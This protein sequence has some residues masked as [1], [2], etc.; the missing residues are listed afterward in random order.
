M[1]N[2]DLLSGHPMSSHE[3]NSHSKLD[4]YCMARTVIRQNYFLLLCV[5]FSSA[6]SSRNEA[7][8]ASVTN[9]R[10]IS[11][12]RGE[13][14]SSVP[15][16]EW[17]PSY[18]SSSILPVF[19]SFTIRLKESVLLIAVMHS[20]KTKPKTQ[21]ERRVSNISVLHGNAHRLLVT[22]TITC[23]DLHGY[24]TSGGANVLRTSE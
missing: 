11:R 6:N 14:I 20:F 9:W 23:S 4:L 7:S 16:I 17:K 3:A 10:A 22:L 18:K 13:T 15:I 21:H 24:Q 12:Q 1:D 8:Y 5:V 19:H 2:P